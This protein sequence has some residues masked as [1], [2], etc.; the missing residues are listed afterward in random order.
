[1]LNARGFVE[2]EVE[3]SVCK[4]TYTA[5]LSDPHDT[6]ICPA[7]V[8]NIEIAAQEFDELIDSTLLDD[9]QIKPCTEE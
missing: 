5:A 6:G 4:H 3:C 1:M 9:M 7:C 8:E 2:E